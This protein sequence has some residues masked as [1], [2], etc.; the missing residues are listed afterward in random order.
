MVELYT[1]NMGGVDRADQLAQYYKI[2]HR[3]LKWW[4]KVFYF[5]I[6]LSFWNSYILYAA[7]TEKP[8]IS[9]KYCLAVVH[10]LLDGYERPQNSVG[11]R[12]DQVVTSPS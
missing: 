7:A 10:S 6:E 9:G 4:K 8:L 5:L 1:K 12:P 11:R 2:L 3:S